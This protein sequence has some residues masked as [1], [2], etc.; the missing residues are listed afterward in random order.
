MNDWDLLFFRL[1]HVLFGVF[2]AGTA[3]FLAAFMEPTV[4]SL[5]PDGGRFMQIL[6]QRRRLPIYLTIASVLAIASGAILYWRDSGHLHWAWV[7]TG[8]GLAFTLGGILAVV[9]ALIGPLV[10]APTANRLGVVAQR[11]QAAGGPPNPADVAELIALQA[12]L[13]SASRV[14][15]VLLAAAAAAM[16]VRRYLVVR[17]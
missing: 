3:I 2:W 11:V 15:A 5:G 9:D 1:V 7:K 10:S 4:H 13:R 16:A 14:G 8:P 6:M 12:R 17:L